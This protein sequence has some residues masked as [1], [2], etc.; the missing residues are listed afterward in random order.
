MRQGVSELGKQRGLRMKRTMRKKL[1][2]E[3][4]FGRSL[5]A[6]PIIIYFHQKVR[7]FLRISKIY[8]LLKKPSFLLNG[9]LYYLFLPK[10]GEPQLK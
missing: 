5:A 7:L 4:T 3:A 1:Q 9:K 2:H 8:F 10:Y 6:L